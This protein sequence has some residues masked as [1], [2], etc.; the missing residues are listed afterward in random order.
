MGAMSQL[1]QATSTLLTPGG[2]RSAMPAGQSTCPLSAHDLP[3][4]PV[5]EFADHLADGNILEGPLI[6]AKRLPGRVTTGWGATTEDK[7][8]KRRLESAAMAGSMITD[9]FAATV[10]REA[11]DQEFWR[12]S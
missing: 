6:V 3:L 8:C 11:D 1:Q 10:S 2:R 7:A 12:Q 9:R 4:W 5:G